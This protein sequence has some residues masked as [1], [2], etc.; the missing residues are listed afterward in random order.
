LTVATDQPFKYTGKPFDNEGGIGLYYYGARYYAPELGRFTAVDPLASK[1]PGLS[2]YVYCA[3]NPMKFVDP[4]GRQILDEERKSQEER[5]ETDQ[6][7]PQVVIN[8]NDKAQQMGK[9]IAGVGQAVAETGNAV[10]TTGD[11]VL[12]NAKTPAGAGAL[13]CYAGAAVSASIGQVE[14]AVPLKAAGDALTGVVITSQVYQAAK[15]PSAQ[16]VTA[17]AYTVATALVTRGMSGSLTP[18]ATFS[19]GSSTTITITQEGAVGIP[20]ATSLLLG[21]GSVV[22]TKTHRQQQIDPKAANYNQP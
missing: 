12:T 3:N 1:Y 21:A 14:A 11:A 8:Q 5:Q 19:S 9:A 18:G 22:D 16:N 7:N 2:P 17:A 20:A 15:N 4:D 13:L 10:A 6:M